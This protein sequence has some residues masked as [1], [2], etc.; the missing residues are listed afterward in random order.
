VRDISFGGHVWLTEDLLPSYHPTETSHSFLLL[1]V[2]LSESLTQ[3]AK[4]VHDVE[5]K[6]SEGPFIISLNSNLHFKAST[7]SNSTFINSISAMIFGVIFFH[8]PCSKDVTS[9][10]GVVGDA[11]VG[12]FGRRGA[13]PNWRSELGI[14]RNLEVRFRTS[15]VVKSCITTGQSRL[16]LP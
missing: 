12:W 2:I 11:K 1:N 7:V 5:N 15:K 6:R 10:N 13:V 3:Y 8:Y 9:L 16:E 4:R 14:S